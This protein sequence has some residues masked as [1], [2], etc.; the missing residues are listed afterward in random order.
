MLDDFAD[1]RRK[2]QVS[3]QRAIEVQTSLI[4]P[5]VKTML[6]LRVAASSVLRADAETVDSWRRQPIVVGAEKLPVSVLRHAEDQTLLALKAVLG[7]R[8]QAGCADATFADWGVIAAPNFFGR[9]SIAMTL[10]RFQQ[11]G[12][13][14]VSPHLIPHQSLHAVSGTI[15]QMLKIHGPNFGVAGGPNSAPDAFLLAASLMMDGTLPGL[16]LV[17]SGHAAEW[18]PNAKGAHPPAPE[19]V[20]VALALTADR[21]GERGPRLS[22]G[23]VAAPTGDLRLLPMLDVGLFAEESFS[24]GSLSAGK[25]RIGESHWIEVE[26]SLEGP[27]AQS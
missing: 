12:A 4:S 23:S 11:E 20:A 5:A 3:Y 6:R 9:V 26:A 16:W 10:Q 2:L 7:A 21:A 1:S 13:W 14:G 27:E 8:S 15:S 25:W 17:L 18:I 22:I 19:C 24:M